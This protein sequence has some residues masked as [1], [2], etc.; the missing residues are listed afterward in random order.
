[1]FFAEQKF[2]SCIK[3]EDMNEKLIADDEIGPS[4]LIK[5]CMWG[6]SCVRSIPIIVAVCAC[7]VGVGYTLADFFWFI[8]YKQLPPAFVSVI[9]GV[10]LAVLGSIA[11]QIQ[12][13]VDRFKEQNGVYKQL[14]REHKSQIE[15]LKEQNG[16]Y[17]KLNSE[18][19][20]A[21]EELKVQTEELMA[22][23]NDLKIQIDEFKI[24]ADNLRAQNNNLKTQV[25]VLSGENLSLK[26]SIEKIEKNYHDEEKQLTEMLARNVELEANYQKEKHQLV[27]LQLNYEKEKQ[28]LAEIH[29]INESLHRVLAEERQQVQCLRDENARLGVD[30]KDLGRDLEKA[31]KNIESLEKDLVESRG[32]VGRLRELQKKSAE[33][34]A[35]MALYGEETKNTGLTLK[36]ITKELTETEHHL[37]DDVESLGKKLDLLDTIIEH[38]N[39]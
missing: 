33:A 13:Q 38:H 39:K 21:V 25:G 31:E 28:Q 22:Q 32:L 8:D 12:A 2:L 36:E 19:E 5:C 6:R 29:N 17:D 4:G 15:Q 11:K 23:N 26:S 7:I 24:Q 18:H 20:E 27:E 1:M 37:H 14:N 30:L 35:V 9:C 34:I 3:M 16:K 10:L